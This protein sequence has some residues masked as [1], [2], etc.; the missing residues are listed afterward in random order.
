MLRSNDGALLNL[1]LD[2]LG[3]GMLLRRL[4]CENVDSFD[5]GVSEA[6]SL[7]IQL[8]RVLPP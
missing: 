4:G 8:L 2:E 3:P 5:S 6:F 1:R 7:F